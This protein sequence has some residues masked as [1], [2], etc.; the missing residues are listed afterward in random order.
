M[1]RSGN[2]GAAAAGIAPAGIVPTLTV[3]VRA[4][5]ACRQI[6]AGPAHGQDIRRSRGILDRVRVARRE[7]EGHRIPHA[8]EVRVA[9]DLGRA[10]PRR[11]SYWT[12]LRRAASHTG[13]R[14]PLSPPFGCGVQ[15]RVRV[16]VGL[17]QDNVASGAMVCGRST[18][19]VPRSTSRRWPT[20][21]S[22]HSSPHSGSCRPSGS[23]P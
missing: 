15:V 9:G 17:E 11:P 14:S 5:A 2:A 23:R 8:R 7:H 18:S 3:V 19:R 12:R 1:A 20:D 21:W 16:V 4:E 22:W 10:L 13:C 6:Q